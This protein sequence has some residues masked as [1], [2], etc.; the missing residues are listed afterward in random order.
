[1]STEF[2][3]EQIELIKNTIAKGATDQEL[4]LFVAICGRTGLDPF[5]RQIYMIERRFK[6]YQ[7][8]WQRKME[9]QASI[10]G[11][12]VI[13]E[14]A[15]TYQGQVGPFWCGRDGRWTDVWLEPGNPAAAK[16]GVLKEGFK[17]PLWSVAKWESYVQLGKE[18]RPSK[19]WEKMPDLMLAKCAEA[20]AL[21]R[22][23]P[24]DLSGIYTG[25]EM[26]QVDSLPASQVKQIEPAKEEV[27][28]K[29]GPMEQFAP[30]EY[31][32]AKERNERENYYAPSG[33]GLSQEEFDRLKNSRRTVGVTAIV[34]AKEQKAEAENDLDRHLGSAGGGKAENPYGSDRELELYQ[35]PFGRYK[36]KT[37]KEIGIQNASKYLDWMT[38][39]AKKNGKELSGPTAEFKR[40]VQKAMGI[41]P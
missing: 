1:M 19:M 16:V 29:R 36:G 5:S 25:D 15:G 9:I 40:I 39:E 14:K 38:E 20:L 11:F 30:K 10:D 18:G 32:E 35:V 41:T 33:P 7:G 13:A 6:D 26:S 24:N 23:F 21:R 4:A 37:I 31:L 34:D 28:V 3:R 27:E 17:E 2:S 12:R 8:N 22:A